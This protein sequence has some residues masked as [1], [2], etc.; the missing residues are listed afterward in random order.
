MFYKG[1][2]KKTKKKKK[3]KSNA[4]LCG[5]ITIQI[6]FKSII[7]LRSIEI[8]GAFA[9]NISF[10]L[11]HAFKIVFGLCIYKMAIQN[12]ENGHFKSNSKC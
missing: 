11:V 1:G 4:T 5:C 6:D 8:K 9:R 10:H 2:K 7:K 12:G 3:K